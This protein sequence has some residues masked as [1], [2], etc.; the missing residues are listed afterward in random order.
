MQLR[1]VHQNKIS[2]SLFEILLD[3]DIFGITADHE[4]I[5]FLRPTAISDKHADPLLW[6]KTNNERFPFVASLAR[7]I[8]TVQA[9][10]VASEGC[11][12]EVG[13]LVDVTRS[14]LNSRKSDGDN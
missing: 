11:V 13:N 7:D 6:R 14:S 12:T 2:K 8:L 10:S 5:H 3:E 9:S 1:A 4:I